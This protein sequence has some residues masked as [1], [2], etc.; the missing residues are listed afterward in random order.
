MLRDVRPLRPRSP[1]PAV[2]PAVADP[3]EPP[4]VPL[5]RRASLATVEEEAVS[6]SEAVHASED[7]VFADFCRRIRVD[8]IREYED[9]QLRVA[10]AQ[11]EARMRYTAQMNRLQRQLEFENEQ[12]EHTQSRLRVLDKNLKTDQRNLSQL[13]ADKAELEKEIGSTEHE[14]E[15]IKHD[16]EDL[17]GKLFEV[18]AEL[19]EIK[20][21]SHKATKA[22]DRTLKEVAAWARPSGPSHRRTL[23]CVR[24]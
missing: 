10:E 15:Q 5:Q 14:V 22:F 3:V 1:K 17:Q 2:G 21:R 11:T 6:V 24:C 7:E 23:S 13:E 19:D 16:I 12:L 4:F 9:V 20:R 8:N 18:G